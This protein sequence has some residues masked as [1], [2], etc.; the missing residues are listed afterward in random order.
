MANLYEK[1][2]LQGVG[3]TNVLTTKIFTAWDYSVTDR[4]ACSI[5]QQSIAT[6]IEVKYATQPKTPQT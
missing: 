4:E 3:G 5:K 2:Y 6:D 1:N